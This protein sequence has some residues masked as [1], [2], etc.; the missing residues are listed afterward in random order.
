MFTVNILAFVSLFP[1]NSP[2]INSTHSD[3]DLSN[4]E[5]REVLMRHNREIFQL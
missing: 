5:N 4:K 1:S 3:M 2:N